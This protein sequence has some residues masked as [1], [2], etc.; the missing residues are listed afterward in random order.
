LWTILRNTMSPG[1]NPC[2]CS[3]DRAR[4]PSR[5]ISW[6]TDWVVANVK[7][8]SRDSAPHEMASTS[9]S[10]KRELLQTILGSPLPQ[11][12]QSKAYLSFRCTRLLAPSRSLSAFHQLYHRVVAVDVLAVNKREVIYDMKGHMIQ[13]AS[14]PPVVLL[15]TLSGIG[16]RNQ[17]LTVSLVK[18]VR[19][20]HAVGAPR[21][22]NVVYILQVTDSQSHY[23]SR[24]LVT[25]SVF[26]SC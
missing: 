22:L 16:R 12:P 15:L 19:N 2:L 7:I 25:L 17:F 26:Q 24:F 3:A 23:A 21:N 18:C 14:C 9:R 5:T 8:L 10:R 1:K 6:I 11:R 13:P 20:C 4:S